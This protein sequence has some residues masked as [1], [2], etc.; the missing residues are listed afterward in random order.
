[1]IELD[2]K[3]PAWQ[4]YLDYLREL[5]NNRNEIATVES[6]TRVV[7]SEYNGIV[8]KQEKWLVCFKTDRDLE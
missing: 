2:I 3:N 6:L 1:M 4:R 7:N 8:L 5:F